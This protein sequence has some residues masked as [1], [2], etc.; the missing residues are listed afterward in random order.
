MQ[1][2]IPLHEF[3]AS[4]EDPLAARFLP[5]RAYTSE[6]FYRFELSA[7][8][9]REWLCV[10]RLEEI[11]EPGDYFG[12]SIADEPLLVVRAGEDEVAAMSAVCRHRGRIVA[13]GT[14]HCRKAVVRPYH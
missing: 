13:E 10:G 1:S 8:W 14:G 9:D 5:P 2:P 4:V 6:D 12:I 11:P 3:D 7:I